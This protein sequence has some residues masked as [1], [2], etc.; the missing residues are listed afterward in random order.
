MGKFRVQKGWKD[1]KTQWM[2]V[3]TRG[4]ICGWHPT[5]EA[6]KEHVTRLKAADDY[7]NNRNQ[8]DD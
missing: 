7:F 2:A 5:C 3:H 6:A 4:M 1:G 8:A